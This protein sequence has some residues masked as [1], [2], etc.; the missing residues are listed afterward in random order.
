MPACACEA[1]PALIVHAGMRLYSTARA[2]LCHPPAPA[3]HGTVEHSLPCRQHFW[4]QVLLQ[5]G[6]SMYAATLLVRCEY[7]RY[8]HDMSW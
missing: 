6:S 8:L 4:Q 2:F 5:H 3:Q 1:P 7:G